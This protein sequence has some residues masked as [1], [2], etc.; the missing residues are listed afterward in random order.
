M[1][2]RSKLYDKVKKEYGV[3]M[4]DFLESHLN[5]DTPKNVIAKEIG[6]TSQS[7]AYHINKIK[8]LRLNDRP[9]FKEDKMNSYNCLSRKWVDFDRN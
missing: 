1:E 8:R 4:Y 3:D 9:E 5:K 2:R 6:L 7:I